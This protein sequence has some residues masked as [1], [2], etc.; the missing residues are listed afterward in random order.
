MKTN[1]KKII[2]REG[3]IVVGVVLLSGLLYLADDLLQYEYTIFNYECAYKGEVQKLDAVSIFSK[4]YDMRAVLWKGFVKESSLK[5]SEKELSLA[6]GTIFTEKFGSYP[7]GFIVKNLPIEYSE[8][9][10][11]RRI[12]I[13][14]KIFLIYAY[15]IYVFVRYHIWV[16]RDMRNKGF[17][18]VKLVFLKKF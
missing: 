12:V 17:N 6:D 14:A 11:L 9:G 8:F 3:L 1:I 2:A 10:F 13:N 5:L 18:N 7:S 16:K 4:K 15:F